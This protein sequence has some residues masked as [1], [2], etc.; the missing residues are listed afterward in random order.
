MIRSPLKI[1][2]NDTTLSALSKLYNTKSEMEK[3]KNESR[4]DL[5]VLDVHI[6]D[7]FIQCGILIC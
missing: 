2:N 5:L 1:N 4:I 7:G 3:P 6:L